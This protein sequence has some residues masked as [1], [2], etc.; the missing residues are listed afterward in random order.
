MTGYS[1]GS[2]IAIEL[3]RR[4]EAKGLNGKL[5]LID[6]AP[7]QLKAIRNDQPDNEQELQT[8]TL[9]DMIT[10]VSPTDSAQASRM[11]SYG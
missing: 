4:L 1:F 6:G 9:V 10:I 5:I 8:K 3:T 7:D 11:F 2:L